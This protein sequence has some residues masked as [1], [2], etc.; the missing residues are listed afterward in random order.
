MDWTMMSGMSPGIYL[1]NFGTDILAQQGQFFPLRLATTPL[2]LIPLYNLQFHV[3]NLSSAH[4]YVRLR[5]GETWDNI[6]QPLLEDCAQL[7]KA[8]SIEGQSSTI[9]PTIW[10]RSGG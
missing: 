8:N 4:V 3:D 10:Y 2:A 7:T 1:Q 5:E 6:A 9:N